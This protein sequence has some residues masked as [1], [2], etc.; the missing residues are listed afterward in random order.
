M[1]VVVH[2]TKIFNYFNNIV[3]QDKVQKPH[4]FF[5]AR[6]ICH[7][8]VQIIGHSDNYQCYYF[9]CRICRLSLAVLL[10]RMHRRL[11]CIIKKNNYA[12][13]TDNYVYREISR[14]IKKKN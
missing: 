14:L 6:S 10:S 9:S 4:S 5:I 8:A 3:D 13:G 2:P 1:S 11:L 7:I 12:S